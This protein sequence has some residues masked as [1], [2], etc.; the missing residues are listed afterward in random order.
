VGRSVERLTHAED[1]DQRVDLPQ[2]EHVEG[3]EGAEHRDR[4]AADHVGEDQQLPAIEPVGEHARHQHEPDLRKAPRDPH[5]GERARAV[6]LVVHLPGDRHDV[7]TV[8]EER[9]D[10]AEPQQPEVAD[11]ERSNDAET[12]WGGHDFTSLVNVG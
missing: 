5:A 8:A 4:Q 6:P 3:D 2:H 9:H 7:D 1:H 12:G 10:G 11:R